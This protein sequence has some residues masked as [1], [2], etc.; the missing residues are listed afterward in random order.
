MAH[1]LAS[2]GD[3]PGIGGGAG[4]GDVAGGGGDGF[5]VKLG[6]GEGQ[7]E[8]HD[9]IG[10]G[11]AVDEEGEGH[12]GPILLLASIHSAVRLTRLIGQSIHF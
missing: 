3:A 11:V 6:G 7:Q 4:D 12:G 1:P 9:V 5:Q 8:G 2:P 10:A